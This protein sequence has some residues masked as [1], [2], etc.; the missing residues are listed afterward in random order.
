MYIIKKKFK[1][2]SWIWLFFHFVK[3]K[4]VHFIRAFGTHEIYIFSLHSWNKSHI[5]SKHL[6]I[7]YIL[8]CICMLCIPIRIALYLSSANRKEGYDQESIQLPNTFRSKT[9][10]GKNITKTCLYNID[11]LKPHFYIVKL[12]FTVVYIIFLISAQKHRLWVLVSTAST[13]RF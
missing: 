4:N 7:L 13:R 10:K 9:P 8:S 2:L 1:C 3:W 6:N 12:G 5:H 11:S